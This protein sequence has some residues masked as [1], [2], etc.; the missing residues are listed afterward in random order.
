MPGPP[1]TPKVPELRLERNSF[2][3][4]AY[5]STVTANLSAIMEAA[6]PGPDLGADYYNNYEQKPGIVFIKALSGNT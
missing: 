2:I 3:E 1:L 4:S 6:T 5:G